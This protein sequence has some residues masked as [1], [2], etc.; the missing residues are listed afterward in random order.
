MSGTL[1]RALNSLGPSM[2][3]AASFAGSYGKPLLTRSGSLVSR[4]GPV[5]VRLGG[6]CV[7]SMFLNS[8]FHLSRYSFGRVL[9]QGFVSLACD[10][11][12]TEPALDWIKRQ[13]IALIPLNREAV[14]FCCFAVRLVHYIAPIVLSK[15]LGR[16][17]GDEEYREV[18]EQR[19]IWETV[20]V[21]DEGS[22]DSV[23]T[24]SDEDLRVENEDQDL[25]IEEA[26]AKDKRL[27]TADNGS[28]PEI[29]TVQQEEQASQ[30]ARTKQVQRSRTQ[31]VQVTRELDSLG[32]SFDDS[33]FTFSRWDGNWLAVQ[34][35]F[36]L[37]DQAI[38]SLLRTGSL[39]LIPFLR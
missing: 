13:S 9:N 31:W 12:V 6:A 10:A 39:K 20:T 7:T 30:S 18:P 8:V 16:A 5:M 26:E 28:N 32:R 24:E 15:Y 14:I 21:P 33:R 36:L 35:T 1:I 4:M 23:E 37:A 19:V 22:D 38:K 11:L 2:V 34:M 27:E 17:L 3:N 25:E 29:N